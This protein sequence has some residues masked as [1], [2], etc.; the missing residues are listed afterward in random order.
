MTRRIRFVAPSAWSIGEL[1]NAV[2]LAQRLPEGVAADFLVSSKHLDYARAA[3]VDARVLPRGHAAAAAVR[4]AVAEPGLDGVVLADHH[5]LGLERTG[6]A[7][8]D[9]RGGAPL[10]ALDSLAFGAGPTTLE[11]AVSRGSDDPML[12]RFFPPVVQLAAVPDDVP[13]LR[14]VPVAG[15]G[16]DAGAGRAAAPFDLYGPEG[17]LRGRAVDREAVRARL[18]VEPGRAL[19]V[20]AMSNW[21]STAMTRPGLGGPNPERDDYL[22]LRFEWWHELLRRLDRPV[23]L[24][25]VSAEAF[26]AEHDGARADV[27]T[28]ATGFLPLDRFTELLAAADLYLTDNLTS[29]AMA[30]AALLG[31]PV[32]A[33]TR[34]G[35]AETDDA[36]A[37]DWRARMRERFPRAGFDYLVN[38][39]GWIDEL[40]PLLADNPYLAAVP[41]IHVDDLDAQLRACRTALD[42]PARP[43]RD[44]LDAQRAAL[45]AGPPTLLA[46]LGTG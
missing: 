13:L 3:G 32:V 22:R 12:R 45:P 28:I 7:L 11:L 17:P 5:L 42:D 9:L 30:R 23:A 37:R 15:S 46:A 21:A 26:E 10:V 6:L 36:F 2:E 4:E 20:I 14:P 34:E 40:R 44:A 29:G 38:P 8:D 25:G 24:V 41:R 18:G 1:A 27:R 31:A 33:L 35:P 19:V 43:A 39:F 16:R